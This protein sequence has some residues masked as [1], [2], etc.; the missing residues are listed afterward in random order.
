[1]LFV[2]SSRQRNKGITSN[3]ASK[4]NAGNLWKVTGNSRCL[5]FTGLLVERFI[6]GDDIF[7]VCG[8]AWC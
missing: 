8:L 4:N 3:L 2:H 6:K 7:L 1:M 5:C